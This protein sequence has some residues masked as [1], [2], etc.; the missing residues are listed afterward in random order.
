MPLFVNDKVIVLTHDKTV[1][2]HRII[3]NFQCRKI[4]IAYDN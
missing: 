2:K 4:T 1:V 3:R